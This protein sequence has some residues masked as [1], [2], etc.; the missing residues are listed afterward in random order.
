VTK[1]KS[2]E[3]QV[4]AELKMIKYKKVFLKIKVARAVASSGILE[5]KIKVQ[6]SGATC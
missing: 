6:D 2:L 4:D 3:L 5:V 1:K